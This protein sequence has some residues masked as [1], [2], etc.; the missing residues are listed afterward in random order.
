MLFVVVHADGCRVIYFSFSRTV[1][2]TKKRSVVFSNRLR[3]QSRSGAG[4]GGQGGAVHGAAEGAL[5]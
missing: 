2:A 3:V 4:G 5:A 1:G